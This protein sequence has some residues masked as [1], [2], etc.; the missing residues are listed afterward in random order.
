MISRALPVALRQVATRHGA[1]LGCPDVSG[2]ELLGRSGADR[3]VRV[4]AVLLG[5]SSSVARCRPGDDLARCAGHDF[6]LERS[7]GRPETDMV[8]NSN[9][10]LPR[11]VQLSF[12]AAFTAVVERVPRGRTTAFALNVVPSTETASAK[13]EVTRDFAPDHWKRILAET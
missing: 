2:G 1:R 3:S 12:D 13:H 5:P 9:R 8:G 6:H 11:A 7:A 4:D 10:V